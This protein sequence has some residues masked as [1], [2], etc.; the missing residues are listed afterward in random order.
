MGKADFTQHEHLVKTS[1]EIRTARRRFSASSLWLAQTRFDLAFTPSMISSLMVQATTCPKARAQFAALSAKACKIAQMS[2]GGLRYRPLLQNY[3]RR[4]PLQIVAFPDASFHNL[5]NGGS[6]KAFGILLARPISRD[7]SVRCVGHA[8][9]FSKKKV[10][11]ARR[12]SIS[13][14]VAALSDTID[15]CIWAKSHIWEVY[16]AEFKTEQ[17]SETE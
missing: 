6:M 16:R 12:S 17:L 8:L 13:A 14:E 1:A 10:N 11:M 3:D 4:H 15:A 9:S 5:A 2:G 7:E